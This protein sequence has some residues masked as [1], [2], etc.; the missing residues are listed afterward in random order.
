MLSI[1]TRYALKSL[2]RHPRRTFLSVLG[3]GI[4][5][6]SCLVA[7]SFVRGEGE[8]FMRSVA[9]TGTGHLRIAPKAWDRLRENNLRVA[10]WR[11][12]LDAVRAMEGVRVATPRARAN[13]LVAAGTRTVG[14]EVVG[15]D[16]S[17]EPE[18]NRLVRGE[19]EGRYLR[20]E[21]AGSVEI[22]AVVGEAVAERLAVA[23]D[24]L[25]VLTV[26][27]AEGVM[28]QAMLRIVG[29]FATGSDEIDATIC[30]VPLADLERLTGRSGPGEIVVLLENHKLVERFAAKL[31]AA[32]SRAEGGGNEVLAWHQ[33]SPEMAD[34]VTI[35]ESFT[36]LT[37]VIVVFLVFLGITSAQLTAVLQR[38]R[39]FAVLSAVGMKG[40]QLVRVMFLEGFLI[41]LAG[42]ALGLLLTLPL[43]YHMA[44]AG[45][46][47]A[48]F[49]GEGTQV[50]SGVLIEPVLYGDMGWYLVPYGI[51]ISFLSTLLASIYPARFAARTDPAAA[52]R[53][54]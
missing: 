6:A 10:D 28:Q 49:A 41:G 36:W 23:I 35:D 45:L 22:A 37:V 39:E 50:M 24:D 9:E 11:S 40:G 4:G 18:S 7:I 48:D 53:A 47:L 15:V 26:S 16:P 52:L 3:V 17:T 1:S 46:D 51:V 32:P 38:R 42:T 13:A 30:Q 43:V 33:V 5:C 14:V 12:E 2:L 54:T 21:D 27:D 8:L 19:P 44:T 31:R 20:A 34:A 29:L 25:A